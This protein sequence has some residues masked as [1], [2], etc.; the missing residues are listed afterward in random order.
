[1]RRASSKS[2]TKRVKKKKMKKEKG[3]LLFEGRVLTGTS[4]VP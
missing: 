1:M 2:K 4:T 3:Q